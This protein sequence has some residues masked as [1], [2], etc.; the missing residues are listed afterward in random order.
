MACSLIWLVVNGKG[1]TSVWWNSGAS[2][3]S[4]SISLLF[5]HI[6]TS[7]WLDFFQGGSGLQRCTER[8][9]ERERQ[10]EAVFFI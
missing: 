1:Q 5:P 10:E 4:F 8:E 6:A 9:R 7:R 2:L 3:E